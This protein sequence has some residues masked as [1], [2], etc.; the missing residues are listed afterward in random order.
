MESR[1]L[2]AGAGAIAVAIDSHPQAA[3]KLKA[4]P[5]QGK[6]AKR[7][8]KS[9]R[10]EQ[11]KTRL[12]GLADELKA[13]GF[14]ALLK[15]PAAIA[16]AEAPDQ[17]PKTGGWIGKVKEPLGA[18]IQRVSVAD[19]FSQRPPFDHV[20]DP[21]YRRL[22]RDFIEGALVPEA[23]VAALDSV[24]GGKIAELDHREIRCSIIDGLQRLYCMCIA[25][26]LVHERHR[27]VQEGL[28]PKQAWDYFADAV[29]RSGEPKAATEKMLERAIRYE[30]F[31]RIDLGG[32]LHYM[33][34]F[35]TGQ[36]R[37]SLP[38]QLEIMKRPLIDELQKAGI[39]V[40]CE[41]ERLPGVAKQ[42]GEFAASDLILATQAFVSVNAHVSAA[43]EA[44]HYL[45]D[46]IYLEGIGDVEDAVAALKRVAGELHPRVMKIYADDE[47]NRYLI[48]T[49]SFLFGLVA[50]CGYVRN[51]RGMSVLDSQL[52]RVIALFRKDDYDPL[53][54][55]EYWIALRKMAPSRGKAI[56]RLVDDTFRRF[57]NGA[58]NG[59]DWFDTAVSLG[60][61]PH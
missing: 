19:N 27:L 12:I 6:P 26:L 15:P 11:L 54:L 38:I 58:T 13:Q 50:A 60:A 59:L 33:V 3:A 17:D 18:Y 52:D 46:R 43:P 5:R 31:Y 55:A 24:S 1:R 22:I 7:P 35:N 56:R 57:F 41:V 51:A 21:I 61:T 16:L 32:L 39:S 25:V 2:E 9:E 29:N 47:K 37:M 14:S 28:I 4:S 23:K 53:N 20:T 34:T 8:K 45:E 36:R 42:K 49:D 48:A 40:Q 30:I 10:A 44:N